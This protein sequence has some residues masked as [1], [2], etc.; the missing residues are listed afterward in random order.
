MD[1]WDFNLKK[2][3]VVFNECVKNPYPVLQIL[4]QYLIDILSSDDLI[5]PYKTSD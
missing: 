1:T 3:A 2:I 5:L 4:E